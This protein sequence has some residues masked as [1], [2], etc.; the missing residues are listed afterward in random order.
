MIAIKNQKLKFKNLKKEKI[1]INNLLRII[2]KIIQ[3]KRYHYMKVMKNLIL[4]IMN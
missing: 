1:I 3:K 2:F 4:K